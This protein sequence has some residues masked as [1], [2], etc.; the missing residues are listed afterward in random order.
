[1]RITLD[2]DDDVVSAARSL[3]AAERRSV[4]SVVSEF[5]RRGL[6]LARMGSEDGL[7]VIRVP[8]GTPPLTPSLVDRALEQG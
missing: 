3:A 6:T 7:P 4:G 1:M 2:L 5:A 8:S